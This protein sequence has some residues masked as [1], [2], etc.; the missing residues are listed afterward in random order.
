MILQ[1]HFVRGL[2][3]ELLSII[4]DGIKIRDTVSKEDDLLPAADEVAV[5]VVKHALVPCLYCG[6]KFGGVGALKRHLRYC[7]ANQNASKRQKVSPPDEAVV[8]KNSIPCLYCDNHFPDI[9]SL[10]SHLSA[11]RSNKRP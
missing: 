3:W 7:D 9:S 11:C 6:G 8:E 2:F 1:I 5:S 4:A 10:E